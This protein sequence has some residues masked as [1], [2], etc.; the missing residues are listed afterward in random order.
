MPGITSQGWLC[1]SFG[2]PLLDTASFGRTWSETIGWGEGLRINPSWTLLRV[3]I[4]S[5]GCAFFC[6]LYF[7]NVVS[8]YMYKP[9]CAFALPE[10]GFSWTMPRGA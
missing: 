4:L 10:A 7:S 2:G 6:D 5:V 3:W 8:T 1:L 9:L